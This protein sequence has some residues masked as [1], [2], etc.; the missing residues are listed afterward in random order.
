MFGGASFQRGF[1][2]TQHP[3]R[4][5]FIAVKKEIAVDMAFDGVRVFHS[6]R[7]GKP[8]GNSHEFAARLFV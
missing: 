3:P 6:P 4:I 8:D 1:H 2:G 7:M 5:V